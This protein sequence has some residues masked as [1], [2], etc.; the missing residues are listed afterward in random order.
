MEDVKYLVK[1]SCPNDASCEFDNVVFFTVEK[2]QS[3]RVRVEFVDELPQ[4]RIKA[5]MLIHMVND[6]L[7][8]LNIP[9]PQGLSEATWNIKIGSH[10][11]RLKVK[12]KFIRIDCDVTGSWINNPALLTMVKYIRD[13]PEASVRN[14]VYS[15]SKDFYKILN[16]EKVPRWSFTFH[17]L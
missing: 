10:I 4:N 1:A 15:R 2:K 16:P 13:I 3:G 11:R 9:L 12:N 8:Q 17:K 5:Y 6:C 14:K 7:K